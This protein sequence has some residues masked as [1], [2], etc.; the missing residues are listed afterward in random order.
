MVSSSESVESASEPVDESV[1]SSASDEDSSLEA[2]ASAL[3]CESSAEVVPWA[4][5]P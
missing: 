1:E 5:Q 3:P 2:L 4:S